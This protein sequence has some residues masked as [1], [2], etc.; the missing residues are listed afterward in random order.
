[1]ASQTTIKNQEIS[2]IKKDIN[3]LMREKERA[4]RDLK[5]KDTVIQLLEQ[6]NEELLLAI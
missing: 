1:M 5:E 6:R 2:R 4:D 3:E